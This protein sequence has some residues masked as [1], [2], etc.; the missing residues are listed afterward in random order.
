ME[1]SGQLHTPA[2]FPQGKSTWYPLIRKLDKPLSRSGRGDD[3]KNSQSPPGVEPRNPH[4]PAHSLV[5]IPA[6][7]SRLLP[8]RLKGSI[9]SEVN[10][11]SE[12]VKGP[13]P[14]NVQFHDFRSQS[15]VTHHMM[16]S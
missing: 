13:N 9:I 3:G 1:V 5:A 14:W 4:R 12:Q 15:K 6:A 8:K 10:T 16:C 7:L 11:K 2:D